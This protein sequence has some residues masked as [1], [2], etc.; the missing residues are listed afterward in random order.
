M[1]A[2]VWWMEPLW[3]AFN[4]IHGANNPGT[5]CWIHFE[6]QEQPVWLSI[7]AKSTLLLSVGCALIK[8]T[9][10]ACKTFMY[11]FLTPGRA[12]CTFP[13]CI[14]RNRGIKFNYLFWLNLIRFLKLHNWRQQKGISSVI[15]LLRGA[16]SC[17]LRKMVATSEIERA[18]EWKCLTI[19]PASQLN[20][21]R[22]VFWK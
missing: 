9:D 7:K 21:E 13:E 3:N 18:W 4:E 8:Q 12:I 19:T 20:T 16:V 2:S 6:Q 11:R 1:H 14:P 22:S 5:E 10:F 15:H 17:Y